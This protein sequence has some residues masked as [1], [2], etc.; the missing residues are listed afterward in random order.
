MSRN[1]ALMDDLLSGI[2]QTDTWK[3]VQLQNPEI[4]AADKV[5]AEALEKLR[6]VAP[7]E[8]INQIIDA[9]YAYASSF[10]TAA[11]LYGVHVA[12]TLRDCSAHSEEVSQFILDR[13]VSRREK[14]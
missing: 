5:L 2:T 7:E 11:I 13:M 4:L 6:G 9:A 3:D 8:V 1:I 14:A 10:E 12:D